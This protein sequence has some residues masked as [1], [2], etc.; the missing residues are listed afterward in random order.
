MMPQI[1]RDTVASGLDGPRD[2]LGGALDGDGFPGSD[3][4]GRPDQ[5]IGEDEDAPQIGDPDD[6]DLEEI[7]PESDEP[8][9]DHDQ[10]RDA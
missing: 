7:D 9:Q 5:P 6:L 1:I 3:P 2:T 4:L 8:E 10:T